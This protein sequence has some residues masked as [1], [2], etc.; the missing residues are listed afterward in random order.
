MQRR[1]KRLK[2]RKSS[3]ALFSTA[4]LLLP[5]ILLIF[6][7]TAPHPIYCSF[8]VILLLFCSTATL[9]TYFS[10]S[11]LQ[12]SP[13]LFSFLSFCASSTLHFSNSVLLLLFSA[14][15]LRFCTNGTIL[16]Y[17][18]PFYRPTVLL[19]TGQMI[20]YCQTV[21]TSTKNTGTL[22]HPAIS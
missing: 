2:K 17:S 22:N 18:S 5:A 20:L 12:Y 6:C 4:E 9:A 1:T 3:S 14:L 21:A 13:F 15:L 11:D 16:F 10:T 7:P 8:S 19:P